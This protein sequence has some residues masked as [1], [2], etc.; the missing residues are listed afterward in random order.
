MFCECY[1]LILN[2]KVSPVFT[3]MRLHSSHA[4][5]TGFADLYSPKSVKS[6][7]IKMF[8]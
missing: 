4:P 7:S 3:G 6:K 2:K 1:H 8:N 5:H